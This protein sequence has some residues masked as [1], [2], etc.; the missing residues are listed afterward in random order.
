M[1][2]K[3]HFNLNFI[4]SPELILVFMLAVNHAQSK[5][6]NWAT[7]KFEVVI[8]GAPLIGQPQIGRCGKFE[9]ATFGHDDPINA[10]LRHPLA[11]LNVQGSHRSDDEDP[12]FAV[13]PT[14][15]LTYDADSPAPGTQIAG[16]R[17]RRRSKRV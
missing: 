15:Q 10:L 12:L 9:I 13:S 6:R 11:D 5:I 1:I 8:I 14:P 17:G 2:I 4:M 3:W 16:F 7:P